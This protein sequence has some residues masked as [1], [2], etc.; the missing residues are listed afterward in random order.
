MVIAI[1]YENGPDTGS[2]GRLNV[3]YL[4][5]LKMYGLGHK[6]TP[7]MHFGQ[8]LVNDEVIELYA[9]KISD[10]MNFNESDD[11]VYSSNMASLTGEVIKF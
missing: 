3:T 10:E 4:S 1:G 8:E 7:Y 11:L 5:N 9:V 2:T 6:R